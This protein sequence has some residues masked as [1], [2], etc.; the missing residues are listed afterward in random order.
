MFYLSYQYSNQSHGA[1]PYVSDLLLN[2]DVT[3]LGHA[4]LFD[5]RKLTFLPAE[6]RKIVSIAVATWLELSENKMVSSASWCR[7]TS[8]S[9]M[10]IPF[11][12]LFWKWV[13]KLCI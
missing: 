8:Q 13:E 11:K 12:V 10:E 4:A 1:D 7:L 3:D 5:G 2:W 9:A 6:M